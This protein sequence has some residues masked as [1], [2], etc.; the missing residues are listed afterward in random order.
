[1]VRVAFVLTNF[2]VGGTELNAVRTAEAL[3]RSR[4]DLSVVALAERGPLI[5]RYRE[6]GIPVRIFPIT[7]LARPHA[8][9]RARQLARHFQREGVEVVH[10]FGIYGNVFGV[11]S[12][13]AAGVPLVIASRR[14]WKRDAPRRLLVA[15]RLSY[16]LAHR[17]V[18]NSDAVGR[19]LVEEDGVPPGRVAVITNFLEPAAFD[20]PPEPWLAEG[21]AELGIEQGDVVLGIVARLVPVKDHAALVRAAAPLLG[22]VPRVRLVLVGDGP[23]RRALSD[24]GRS[25]GVDEH[26]VFAGHRPRTPSYNHLFDVSV[27]C[28]TSEGFPNSVIEAMAAAKPVV[29]TRVG[30]IV[31]AVEHGRTGLLVPAGDVDAL[32]QA[33]ASLVGD[34]DLRRR[35]GQAGRERAR[36]T[37]SAGRVLGQ[38]ERLYLGGGASPKR[39]VGAGVGGTLGAVA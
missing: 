18:G 10:A 30:G 24:L 5:E 33:L 28:S 16:R 14:W 26:V 9:W 2:E 20:D 29:A 19:F 11:P 25:L 23:E 17:V 27:L 3:D 7:S 39:D 36:E 12:A 6:A 34:A 31:D 1:M 22:G 37:Y 15:N 8:L 38:L 21:R 13:R 4:F 35:L 32:R